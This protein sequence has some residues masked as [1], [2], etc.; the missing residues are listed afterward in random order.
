MITVRLM[1]GLGN[2][3][4]QYAAGRALSLR[5]GVG[6]R[7]DLGWFGNQPARDTPRSYELD[8]FV[9]P[10]ATIKE[11]AALSEPHTH[12]GFALLRLRRALGREPQVLRQRGTGFDA[13]ILD[14]PDAA[15]LVGFWTSERYFDDADDVIREDFTPVA[16]L[17][18]RNVQLADEIDKRPSAVSVHVRRGD[19][20]S[21]PHAHRFHG[22]L[23]IDYYRAAV[24]M[25]EERVG[26]VHLYVFSDDPDW[27]S[28][29]LRLGAPTTVVRGNAGASAVD[30]LILMSRCA[31]HIIAN[32]TFSWWGAWLDGRPGS[33]VVAPQRWAIDPASDFSDIYA[34]GWLRA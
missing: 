9:G 3:M 27:C 17:D 14:A 5:R 25:L 32:S 18:A 31:H 15:H 20:V 8:A 10:Q 7:L 29:H 13:S 11:R 6:L 2:Q 33:V 23:G 34:R 21:N 16:P 19:Y 4:F 24:R 30:D 26:E 22:L 12:A 1:G 28:E